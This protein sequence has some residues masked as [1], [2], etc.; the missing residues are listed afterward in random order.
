[1]DREKIIGAVGVLLVAIL[2]TFG[3]ILV[4]MLFRAIGL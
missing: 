2:L 4:D 3:D 1:M